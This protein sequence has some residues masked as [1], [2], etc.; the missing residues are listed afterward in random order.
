VAFHTSP[1]RKDKTIMVT[2]KSKERNKC[3]SNDKKIKSINPYATIGR[4][5]FVDQGG[6]VAASSSRR[7]RRRGGD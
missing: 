5:G 3:E 6:N 7:R 1:R 4:E 2:V